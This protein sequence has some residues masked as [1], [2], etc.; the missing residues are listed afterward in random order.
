MR[1]ADQRQA[2]LQQRRE[3]HLQQISLVQQYR[4]ASDTAEK[5]EARLQQ[6]NLSL[7]CTKTDSIAV[8]LG[9]PSFH[10]LLRVK[11]RVSIYQWR[12]YTR[13]HKGLGPGK[14]LSALVTFDKHA[15]Y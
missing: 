1:S 8:N 13:A 12:G 4:L 2:V 5:K 10:R 15:E 3:A 11:C 9:P 7:I 14:F 6:R